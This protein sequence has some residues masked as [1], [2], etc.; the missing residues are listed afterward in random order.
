MRVVVVDDESKR[1]QRAFSGAQL[2]PAR[3]VRSQHHLAPPYQ[4]ELLPDLL[5]RDAE[6]DAVAAAAEVESQHQPRLLY[7]A[8]A[9]ARAQAEAAMKAVH[10]CRLPLDMMKQR[11]P[12]ER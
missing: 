11:I 5:G 7:R 8:A 2:D 6:G 3:R 9:H 4:R 1:A 12:D 10:C